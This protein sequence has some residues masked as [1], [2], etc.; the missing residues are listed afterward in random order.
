V[1]KEEKKIH[2]KGGVRK[3]DDLIF[4]PLD[5]VMGMD[6]KEQAVGKSSTQSE[7][8]RLGL[9]RAIHQSETGGRHGG[10]SKQPMNQS[11]S[12]D[13]QCKQSVKQ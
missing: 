12:T 7:A 1:S 6:G 2:K 5:I 11:R 10:W 9:V 3:E 13:S 8:M 4:T